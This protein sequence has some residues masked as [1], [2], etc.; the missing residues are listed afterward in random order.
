M[1]IP[2]QTLMHNNSDVFFALRTMEDHH[3]RTGGKPDDPHRHDFYTII[4]VKNACGKHFVDYVEYDLKPGMVF[5]LKPGQVHQVITRGVPSGDII[6]FN[7]EFLTRNFVSKRFI[8]EIGLFSDNMD[9]PPLTFE[10]SC[11]L[12]LVSIS[13]EL[14]N[15]FE[16][17]HRFKFDAIAAYLKL[18]LIECNKAAIIPDGSNLQSIESGRIIVRE[19]KQLLDAN[20]ANWHKVKDYANEMSL[21][22]DY[23]N[24]VLKST[25][26]KTAKQMIVDRLVL[27]AKRLGVHTDQTTKEVAYQLGFDDPSHFSKLFKKE[28][29]QLFSTF[30][31][32]LVLFQ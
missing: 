23:L 3:E 27:E 8:N 31:N 24:N 21:S 32:N 14:K 4:L 12:Q 13:E 2:I 7:D 28:S 9:I 26:G 15:A 1:E 6:M 10:E 18:F 11:F 5:L 20:F 16:G 17:N 30:R 25:I 22:P 19:F 29:G